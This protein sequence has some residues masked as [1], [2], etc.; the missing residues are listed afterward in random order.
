MYQVCVNSE[1]FSWTFITPI[2]LSVSVS[3]I[4]EWLYDKLSYLFFHILFF[5]SLLSYNFCT[6]GMLW[7]LQEFLQYIIVEFTPPPFSFI[8][9][10]PFLEQFQQVSFFHFHTW[11]HNISTIFILLHSFLMSSPL[12]LVPTPRQKLFYLPVCHF[13]KKTFLFI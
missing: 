13:W 8:P 3:T 2:C 5:Y 10:P 7:H 1:F 12:P 6:G 9:P 11:E 4:L